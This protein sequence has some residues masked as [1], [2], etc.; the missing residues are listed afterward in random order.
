[1]SARSRELAGLIVAALLA[2]IALASVTIARDAQFSA[3]AVTWGALFFAL[4]L[5]ARGPGHGIL[6]KQAGKVEPDPRTGQLVTTGTT[7]CTKVTGSW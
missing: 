2:G 5:V 1:M 3:S 7:A 4:Y 6:V